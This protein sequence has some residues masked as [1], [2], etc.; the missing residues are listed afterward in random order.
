[1]TT[2]IAQG[3]PV[4]VT[5]VWI[6]GW[7]K[8]NKYRCP[9]DWNVLIPGNN[10]KMTDMILQAKSRKKVLIANGLPNISIM[11]ITLHKH[12]LSHQYGSAVFA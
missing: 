9:V 3:F 11:L 12:M 4:K 5:F 6:G 7:N 2:L 10:R 8:W 1:M